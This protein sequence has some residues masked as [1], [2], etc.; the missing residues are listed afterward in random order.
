MFRV[1]LFLTLFVG[2][3][4]A[5]FLKL[6]H[7]PDR[8]I[9]SIHYISLPFLVFAIF[10]ENC[11][12]RLVRNEVKFILMCILTLIF[13]RIFVDRSA[14]FAVS[15]N[16]AI[17][18]VFLIAFL[19]S[20]IVK[21][22]EFVKQILLFF[23][24]IECSVA[25]IESISRTIIFADI[26]LISEYQDVEYML[27]NEMRAYSLHG[28]PLQNAFIVSLLSIFFVFDYSK[29]IMFRYGLFAIGYFSLFAFNTRSSIYLMTLMFLY[30]FLNDFKNSKLKI[31]DKVLI[32]TFSTLSFVALVYLIIEYQ[33]GSRLIYSLTASD[34]SSNT[35][36]ILLFALINLSLPQLFF[37]FENGLEIIRNQYS[38]PFAVENSLVNF[39][40]TNG[41]VY[42]VFWCYFIYKCLYEINHNKKLFHCSFFIFFM[43]LNAN[44]CLMT[45]APIVVLYILALY[46]FAEDPTDIKKRIIILKIYC[47][48][49]LNTIRKMQLRK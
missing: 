15:V 6:Y 3:S 48:Y 17:E 46:S 22:R 13:A 19:R 4:I 33:F 38:L 40:I 26:D 10:Q 45:D 16:N 14:M 18:P 9:F 5:S 37:G 7:D 20:N 28:H 39:I 31:R 11:Q 47:L 41:L 24:L 42:T 27:E 25:I 2:N 1:Y 49:T 34:D 43:L 35:R 44:N 30:V 23:F 12:I 36:Y 29:N 32:L 8:F 21:Y